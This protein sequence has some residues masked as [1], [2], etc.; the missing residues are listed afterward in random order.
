M[1]YLL[2]LLLS[3]PP[4]HKPLTCDPACVVRYCESR[5]VGPHRDRLQG[6]ADCKRACFK[7]VTENGCWPCR[8]Q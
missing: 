7:Y 8:E 3:G 4:P 2:F 6:K 5:C 1:M